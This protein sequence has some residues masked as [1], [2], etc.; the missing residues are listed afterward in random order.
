VTA[1]PVNRWSV[2]AALANCEG[3]PLNTAGVARA[4][5]LGKFSDGSCCM[6]ARA[7]L[8]WLRRQRL[9]ALVESAE[10][11][12][13][14]VGHMPPRWRITPAGRRELARRAS[15]PKRGDR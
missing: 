7:A 1:H 11:V 12:H 13:G 6:R 4:A 2:L 9:V 15:A 10:M 5:A 14:R 3:Y 8:A